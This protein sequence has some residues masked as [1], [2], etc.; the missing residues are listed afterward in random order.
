[1]RA[2]LAVD[3]G[4][5]ST[6]A[7]VVG[8]DGVCRGF[9]TAGA[10]NPIS[11]GPTHAAREVATATRRA[12]ASA[13]VERVD[14]PVVLAMAGSSADEGS[15]WIAAELAAAGA[16]GPIRIESDLLATYCAAA[17]EP[18]GYAVVAGT[19]AAAIRVRAG[20]QEL[21]G[22]GLG[23]LLGDGGSGFWIGRR[24]VRAVAAQLDGRGPVT[25]LTALLLADLGIRAG[26]SRAGG[27]RP[28]ALQELVRSV[29][30]LRPIELARFSPLAFAAGD[31]AA[32]AGIRRAAGNALE[33][34]VAAV[35]DPD[36]TGPLVGGGGVLAA[37]A[38]RCELPGGDGIRLVADGTAGAVV[39]AL[40][41]A[42]VGVDR[43]TLEVVVGTLAERRIMSGGSAGYDR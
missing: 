9:G 16:A 8:L 33:E 32:A 3:A 38:A 27:S 23:W 17:W 5:T 11:S 36:V 1:M 37:L 28:D 10:G 18:D 26:T 24:V 2:L 42:G 4:G 13:G 19:G 25:A 31:D 34:A 12:L 6:R 43:A 29:Y 14:G 35:R 7:V 41:A 22:D 30:A 39:L 20:R 15:G 21:V 40:R